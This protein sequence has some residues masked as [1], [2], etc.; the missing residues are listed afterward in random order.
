MGIKL[1]VT[2]HSQ[3]AGQDGIVFIIDFGQ[4]GYVFTR[5]RTGNGPF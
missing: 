2:A 4:T 5:V 3:N 1:K